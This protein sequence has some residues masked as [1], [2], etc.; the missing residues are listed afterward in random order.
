MGLKMAVII[1]LI[2]AMFI[3]KMIENNYFQFSDKPQYINTY[4]VYI[5]INI[6]IDIV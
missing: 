3:G 4:N 5:Y 2:M 6:Y 1:P